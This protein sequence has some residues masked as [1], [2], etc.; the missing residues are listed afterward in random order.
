MSALIYFNTTVF[1]L[2]SALHLYWALG[3]Q[4]ASGAVVPTRP[5]G[6]TLFRPGPALTL[7]VA[8]GLLA[9]A[10]L[11]VATT[12]LFSRWLA[13]RF[14]T[15]ADYLIAAV[16]LLRALGDFRF[17]GFTKRVK[18]TAFAANDTA[19]YTPLCAVLGLGSLLLAL[20]R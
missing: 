2:L 20:S 1:T 11:T 13:P 17:V 16:F 7:L 15:I 10:L 9:F 8:G 6:A 18:G 19:Y 3:G 5:D 12:G 14:V 4:Q